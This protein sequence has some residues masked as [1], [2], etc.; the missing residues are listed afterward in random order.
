MG[1][2]AGL[3][4]GTGLS[5]WAGTFRGLAEGLGIYL[6]STWAPKGFTLGTSLVCVLG[7]LSSTLPSGQVKHGNRKEHVNPKT[8]W[9][10]APVTGEEKGEELTWVLAWGMT[11]VTYTSLSRCSPS[12]TPSGL[13][14]C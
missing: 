7:R 11:R 3:G 8:K 1:A 12:P 5:M 13:A 10:D 6:T 14:G 4:A 9:Q 2:T